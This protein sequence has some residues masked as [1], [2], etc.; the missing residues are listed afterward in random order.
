VDFDLSEAILRKSLLMQ[1]S[2][3]LLLIIFLI[4]TKRRLEFSENFVP[5]K[6]PFMRWILEIMRKWKK[7]LKN[8]LQKSDLLSILQRKKRLERVVT[9]LFFIMIII[10]V[11]RPI[12]LKQ[13]RNLM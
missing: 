7:L 10:S 2:T 13:W 8:M 12:C 11:E 3:L 9:T 1:D 4:L 6:L 5:Q